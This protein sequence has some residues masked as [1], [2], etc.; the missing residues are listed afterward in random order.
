MP[1]LKP[2]MK[3]K[4]N[5]NFNPKIA[6]CV[7]FPFKPH[8]IPLCP[9]SKRLKQFLIHFGEFEASSLNSSVRQKLLVDF[10][11]YYFPQTEEF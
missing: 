2:V 7:L 4:E 5:E 3:R 1:D 6:D 8:K 10:Y 9:F 11:F